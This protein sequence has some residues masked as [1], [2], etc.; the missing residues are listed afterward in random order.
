MAQSVGVTFAIS[1][2]A[3]LKL[4]LLQGN[5][6]IITAFI[7]YWSKAKGIRFAN[8]NSTVHDN[9]AGELAPCCKHSEELGQKWGS[10]SK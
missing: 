4:D 9:S 5:L 8:E 2:S 7:W 3:E 1:L 6:F 10:G